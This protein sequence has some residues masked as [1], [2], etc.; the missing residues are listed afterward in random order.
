MLKTLEKRAQH[1]LWMCWPKKSLNIDGYAISYVV[2]PCIRGAFV[3]A[4]SDVKEMMIFAGSSDRYLVYGKFVEGSF[5]RHANMFADA[6]EGMRAYA[7]ANEMLRKPV[8]TLEGFILHYI[9]G[10][11]DSARSVGLLFELALAYKEMSEAEFKDYAKKKLT[12][13]AMHA[14]AAR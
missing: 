4:T 2:I 1:L 10:H 14:T 3:V 11:A 12:L 8:P 7:S 6:V 5:K 9:Q 13:E